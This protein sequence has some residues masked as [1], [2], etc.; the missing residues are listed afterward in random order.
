MPNIWHG[1]GCVRCGRS[2]FPAERTREQDFLCFKP[3]MDVSSP[4]VLDSG[5]LQTFSRHV[6]F[7]REIVAGKA[8]IVGCYLRDC[9]MKSLRLWKC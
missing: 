8:F 3:K 5:D 1:G 6:D 7:R 4:S 9:P 2:G